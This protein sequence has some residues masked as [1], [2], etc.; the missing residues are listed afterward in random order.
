MG[1]R[2]PSLQRG[3]KIIATDMIMLM[4]IGEGETQT[5]MA[6]LDSDSQATILY[7]PL[8]KVGVRI[9]LMVFEQSLQ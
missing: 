6:L 5:F 9:Q 7:S 8:G 1:P 2:T 4:N 3:L